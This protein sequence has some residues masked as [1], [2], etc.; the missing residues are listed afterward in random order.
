MTTWNLILFSFNFKVN[1]SLLL[2][3]TSFRANI[4]F[5][6]QDTEASLFLKLSFYVKIE[7]EQLLPKCGWPLLLFFH[8][9]LL[10]HFL[11]IGG[12][13]MRGNWKN[14]MFSFQGL[15][16]ILSINSIRKIKK[17]QSQKVILKD[18]NKS[19]TFEKWF[20]LTSERSPDTPVFDIKIWPFKKLFVDISITTMGNRCC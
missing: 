2:Q 7:D 20:F 15:L 13:R 3:I 4:H 17:K 8:H 11:F 1:H 6:L 18:K 14:E 9:P 16:I 10:I 5:L 12:G 19:Q